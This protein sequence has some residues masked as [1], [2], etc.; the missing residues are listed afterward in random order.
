MFMPEELQSQTDRDKMVVT[1]IQLHQKLNFKVETLHLTVAIADRFLSVRNLKHFQ[2][3]IVGITSLWM[4]AKIEETII[5]PFNHWLLLGKGCLGEELVEFESEILK[6]LDYN[7]NIPTAL[8]FFN[9]L[10][11]RTEIQQ[12]SLF[13]CHYLLEL[14]LIDSKYLNYK[15]NILFTSVYYLSM[16]LCD[17]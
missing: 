2:Y 8:S 12:R 16:M 1:I 3:E 6:V 5:P 9:L 7:L 15:Y 17:R 13:L 10:L 4:A 11:A 14:S